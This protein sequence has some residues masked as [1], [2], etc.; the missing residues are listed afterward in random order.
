MNRLTT[1]FS[2]GLILALSAAIVQAKAKGA[3]PP[4]DDTGK[5][6]HTAIIG[7]VLKID[8]VNIVVQTRG[9]D[10]AEVTVITDSK[11]EFQLNTK[12]STLEK[13]KP[14]MEV[15]VTPNTPN[16]APVAKVA[17][18]NDDKKSKSKKDKKKD[19]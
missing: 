1:L 18:T 2:V 3:T 5:K 12:T 14:G 17:A 6:D 7:T 8:G 16:T 13:M 19:A 15:V 9:K 11:T 4:K 10:A